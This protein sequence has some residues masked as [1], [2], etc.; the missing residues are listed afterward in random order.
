MVASAQF[1]QL[2]LMQGRVGFIPD[3]WEF[4]HLNKAFNIR[5]NLRL[6]INEEERSANIG[7]YP[8]YGPTKIQGYIANYQQDGDFALIGEDGDHFLKYRTSSM[9]QL[10]SGKCTVNNHA[11]IIEGTK[12]ASRKWFYYYFMHRD[13][14]SFLTRQ[15]AGR[16]KLNKAAL[17][18]LPVLVPPLPEQ[19]KI[20]QILSTWDKAIT[21]TEQLLV[22][23]KQQ[24]K[25]LMQQLL[26]GKKRLLVDN[27]VRFSGE[28]KEQALEHLYSF[29]KG[30]G[31]SKGSIIST[32][33]N[34][35]ILY[36]EL[37]T[38]YP[39]VIRNVYSRTDSNEGLLSLFGDILI[40]CSTTTNGIDLANATA[41]NEDGLLLG[42]DINVLRPKEELDAIFMSHLLTHIK[43][44]EIASRAQGIT[45]IHLYGKD[46]KAIK[47]KIPSQL[48]EQ[49]KIS[50]VLTNADQEIEVLKQK[51]NY[52][53]QEKKALMQQLLTG[54]RRV[55]V[56]ENH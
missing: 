20:A 21:T 36:G 24:K 1:S 30:K 18:K 48:P 32:G 10:V 38:K 16:Y 2:E 19:N 51:F 8:Y 27:G 13:I 39:E 29:K 35:C 50:S 41:V 43:K 55:Q 17:E 9:T 11:H 6:P 12:K 56:G 47:V 37:Y 4:L 7:P 33:V 15:G 28:W 45:I 26:T 25:A 53:K 22:T 23:A 5:N 3:G 14:F 52:L 31:L 42:G 44:H 46:L 49:Q 40:P 54:K 34:K